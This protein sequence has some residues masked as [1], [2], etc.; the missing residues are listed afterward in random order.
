MEETILIEK[1]KREL[2]GA[3]YVG[4]TGPDFRVADFPAGVMIWLQDSAVTNSFALKMDMRLAAGIMGPF[5]K[6]TLPDIVKPFMDQNVTGVYVILMTPE[7]QR[8]NLRS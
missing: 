8:M 1:M 6:K 7:H 3:K 4:T 2:P 5:G